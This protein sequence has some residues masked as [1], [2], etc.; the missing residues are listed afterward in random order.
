MTD[1]VRPG[2]G[3]RAHIKTLRHEVEECRK[4]LDGSEFH[5]AR[6]AHISERERQIAEL[7]AQLAAAGQDAPSD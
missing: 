5:A 3:L 2:W 4:R 1:N 6:E 7:T